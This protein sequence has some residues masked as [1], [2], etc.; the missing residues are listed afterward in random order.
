MSRPTL[1]M[2]GMVLITIGLV[3][4]RSVV[5]N[6]ISPNGTIFAE[7]ESETNSFRKENKILREK[8]FAK[9][10][11]NRISSEAAKL[12]FVERKDSFKLTEPLPIAKR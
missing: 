9:T 7:I 5:S 1:I 11:L 12:G 8:L 4:A 2:L 10:S 6:A 3:I